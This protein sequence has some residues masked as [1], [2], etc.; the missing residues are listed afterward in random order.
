MY[1]Y[2]F[3]FIPACS[4]NWSYF[5]VYQEQIC[6]FQFYSQHFCL[7]QQAFQTFWIERSTMKDQQTEPFLNSSFVIQSLEDT[8]TP[9]SCWDS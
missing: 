8:R 2:K 1:T 5:S 7:T 4:T 9:T 6:P 3:T